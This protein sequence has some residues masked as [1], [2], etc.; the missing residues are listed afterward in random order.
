MA[1]RQRLGADDDRNRGR[2]LQPVDLDELAELELVAEN[3]VVLVEGEAGVEGV[4]GV[5]ELDVE[6]ALGEEILLVE[7][8]GDDVGDLQEGAPVLADRLLG[9]LVHAIEKLLEYSRRQ[10]CHDRYRCLR[11]HL[12]QLVNVPELGY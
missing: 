7:V 11:D 2:L 12:E 4:G 5:R 3:E 6:A 9:S 10:R 1:S 8:G